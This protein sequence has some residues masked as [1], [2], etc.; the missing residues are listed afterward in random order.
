MA[1]TDKEIKREIELERLKQEGYN[2][3]KKH[4]YHDKGPSFLTDLFKSRETNNEQRENK[5]YYDEGYRKA[6]LEKKK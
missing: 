6:I 5:E 3:G 4:N 2:D 1:K